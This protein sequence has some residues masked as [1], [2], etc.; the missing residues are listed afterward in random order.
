MRDAAIYIVHSLKVNVNKE[1]KEQSDIDPHGNNGQLKVETVVPEVVRGEKR[2]SRPNNSVTNDD[3][4]PG[5]PTDIVKQPVKVQE[6]PGV[7]R[8]AFKSHGPN[9]DGQTHNDTNS[10]TK[11]CKGNKL[12]ETLFV[13]HFMH[14]LRGEFDIP[15]L[16]III[17]C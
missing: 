9:S 4:K 1:L 10:N 14:P 7:N 17:S 3:S 5:K 13:K 16:K 6:K 8:E 2:P 15:M 12:G 11:F